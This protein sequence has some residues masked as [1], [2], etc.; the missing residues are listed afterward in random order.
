[1]KTPLEFIEELAGHLD[2]NA[3]NYFFGEGGMPDEELVYK[4]AFTEFGP[5]RACE[6][7]LIAK[8]AKDYLE[9]Y[10]QEGE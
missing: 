8:A 9:Q 7:Q 4:S 1:M 6:Q 2:V 3:Y 10:K 5:G